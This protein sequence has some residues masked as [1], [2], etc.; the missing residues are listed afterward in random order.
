M[1]RSLTKG[2]V[3]ALLQ[4]VVGAAALAAAAPAL[5]TPSL[6]FPTYSVGPQ[7]DGS[8]VMSTNQTITPAGTLV[9]LGTPTRGKAIAL[10][11]N[12]ANH[13][14]AV[15]QMGAS[16]SV[17][18]FDLVSGQVVQSFS[19]TGDSSGSFTGITYSADGQRLLFGQDSSHLAVAT[20]DP[21]TGLL[22]AAPQVAPPAPSVCTPYPRR[23]P[24]PHSRPR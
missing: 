5:A 15:L 16:S 19:P 14:G 8:V 7:A 17:Q 3:T 4:G 21:T 22:T 6:P 9:K 2:I 13:T 11:P 1:Y 12:P 18:I 10:N 20:V 24:I 23:C